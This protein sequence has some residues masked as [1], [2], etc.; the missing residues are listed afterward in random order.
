MFFPEREPADPDGVADRF[1]ESLSHT[2]GYWQNL[3]GST[4]LILD[5]KNVACRLHSILIDSPYGASDYYIGALFTLYNPFDVSKCEAFRFRVAAL[6]KGD[7]PNIS[8][9]IVFSFIDV[10]SRVAAIRFGVAVNGVFYAKELRMDDPNWEVDPNFD[11]TQVLRFSWMLPSINMN[12]YTWPGCSFWIDVGPFFYW[13][14]E[15]PPPPPKT[16]VRLRCEGVAASQCVIFH[17]EY[18]DTVTVPKD[19]TVSPPGVWGFR[20]LGGTFE[21]WMVN[22]TRYDER[23]ILLDL[24]EGS[25]TILTMY[26]KGEINIQDPI[27]VISMGLGIISAIIS[28]GGVIYGVATHLI[29]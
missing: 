26:Y 17:G 21:Y 23:E 9:D 14:E 29:E 20:A 10:N 16:W 7:P 6:N 1:S 12:P 4:N 3:T 27:A 11:W 8:G 19:F 28:I 25:D 24:A 18:S 15:P 2:E 5:D 22:G 13:W